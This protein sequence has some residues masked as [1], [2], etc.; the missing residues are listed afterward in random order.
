[1]RLKPRREGDEDDLRAEFQRDSNE[2]GGHMDPVVAGLG[3]CCPRMTRVVG[4]ITSRTVSLVLVERAAEPV[5]FLPHVFDDTFVAG[6]STQLLDVPLTTG[7]P[8]EKLVPALV[9]LLEDRQ[10]GLRFV[11]DPDRIAQGYALYGSLGNRFG[12]IR[13]WT[14]A[15]QC[16][17]ERE[18][19][20][21]PVSTWN[22]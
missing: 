18:R 20:G 8:G 13:T 14:R 15:P 5:G 11:G 22:A 16:H 2:V 3:F 21:R 9:V 1:M 7:E 10:H 4:Q 12:D 17:L 19:E 6:E